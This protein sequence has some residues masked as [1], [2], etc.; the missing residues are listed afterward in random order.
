MIL[1]EPQGPLSLFVHLSSSARRRGWAGSAEC[2]NDSSQKGLLA[3]RV[4]SLGLD[5]VLAKG[6]F[7]SVSPCGHNQSPYV[8]LLSLTSLTG[9]C[10][11]V[12]FWHLP[13][14]KGN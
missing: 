2:Q 6:P 7:R 4:L 1:Q 12:L 14:K 8:F 5:L 3:N 11:C 13:H 9:F 10:L